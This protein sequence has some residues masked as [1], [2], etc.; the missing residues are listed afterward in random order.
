MTAIGWVNLVKGAT[1]VAT[2]SEVS[3]PPERVAGDLG[4]AS[5]GWQTPAGVITATLTVIP[6]APGSLLR[7]I[8]IF[9]TNLTYLAQ[10][11]VTGYS[12]GSPVFAEILNG[13][14]PGYRQAILLLP[15]SVYVDGFTIAI[16]DP[17]NPD[18]FLNVPLVFG[19]DLWEPTYPISIQSGYA[20]DR[21]QNVIRTRGGQKIIT[22]I[23]DARMFKFQLPAVTDDEAYNAWGEI[24]RYANLGINYLFIPDTDS[25]DL[26]S[27]AVFG[28]LE[29]V[30]DVGWSTG[31]VRVRSVSGQFVERL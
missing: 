6:A 18:G 14:P 27:E 12:G 3:M 21:Q 28:T 29:G 10:V 26:S 16:V 1:I 31:G 9:R 4:D 23:A 15:A 24:D 5:L 25:P 11:I 19:G 8:G 22:P 7:A 20:R 30:S 17:Y 2:A 13:P